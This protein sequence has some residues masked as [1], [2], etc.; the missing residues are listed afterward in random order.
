MKHITLNLGSS[1]KH[2]PFDPATAI[3]VAAVQVSES[4]EGHTTDEFVVVWHKLG[5]TFAARIADVGFYD[6][7]WDVHPDA[8]LM[9]LEDCDPATVAEAITYLSDEDAMAAA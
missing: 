7:Q 2:L 1:T 4:D 5:T 8:P 3:I 9:I 6:R